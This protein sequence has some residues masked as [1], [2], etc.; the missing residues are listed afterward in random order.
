MRISDVSWDYSTR[1]T[2]S[3]SVGKIS[4]RYLMTP[5]DST[6]DQNPMRRAI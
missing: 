2:I 3:F 4:F 1:N 6:N 5:S